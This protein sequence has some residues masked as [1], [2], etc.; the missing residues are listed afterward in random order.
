MNAPRKL[1]ARDVVNLLQLTV[2]TFT[3]GACALI[4]GIPVAKIAFS[5]SAYAGALALAVVFI[6]AVSPLVA[7]LRYVP[8]D[9]DSG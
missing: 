3:A 7:L 6:I 9:D 5:W 4:V 1:K 2:S 8:E